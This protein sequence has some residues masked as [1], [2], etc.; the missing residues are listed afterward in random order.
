LTEIRARSQLVECAI[1]DYSYV[2]NDCDLMYTRV[3]KFCSIASHVRLNPSNHPMWRPTLHH[4][5]YRSTKYGF[6]GEDDEELFAWRKDHAVDLGHD[7]WIGHAAIVLPGVSIGT[8]AIVGAGAV[9]TKD[10][11]QYA[12]AVGVPAKPLKERFPPKVQEA[13]LRIAWWDWP[14]EKLGQALEDF[15]TKDVRE[16]IAKHD[17]GEA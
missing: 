4:F 13:L 9:V 12:V 5:T 2:M 7:V 17:L 16:F 14:H 15:R 8:G 6:G 10:V 11:P 1:G 3:G